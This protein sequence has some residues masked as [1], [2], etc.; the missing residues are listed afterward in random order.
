MGRRLK[1]LAA[2]CAMLLAASA[3]VTYVFA[4]ENEQQ[5]LND[6]REKD[7]ASVVLRKL[8]KTADGTVTEN[9]ISGAVFR[10]FTA[11]GTLVSGPYTTDENGEIRLSLPA[12]NYY[13]EEETPPDGYTF[14]WDRDGDPIMRYHFT[15]KELDESLLVLAYNRLDTYQPLEMELPNIIKKVEGEDIPKTEF[16]FALEG[17]YAYPMPEGAVGR[18]LTVSRVGKG[19][20]SLG[21]LTFT[22]PGTYTYTLYEVSDGDFSWT[23]DEAV[24]TLTFEVSAKKGKLI[25]ED[26]T[27]RKDEKTADE[28]IFTNVYEKIDLNEKI[29]VSGKKT[30]EHGTNPEAN[31]PERIIV[32]VYADGELVQQRE[33]TEKSNWEYSFEL[34]RYDRNGEEIR[35]VLDEEDVSGYSKAINGYDIVNTYTGTSGGSTS[36]STKPSA[37]PP[38]TGDE[39]ELGFWLAMAALGLCGFV[40][41]LILLLRTKSYRG[42]RLQKKGKRLMRK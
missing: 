36:D 37:K 14:D 20:V 32:K 42:R 3:L 6:L 16:T 40:T 2:L 22:L 19:T 39:F 11:E 30:W 12:G 1:R 29:T 27:I 23:Y 24:Y 10:L 9:V 5:A 8:E 13:F 31:R 25:C 38:K 33:V 4:W 41:V 34:Y 18:T 26:L 35:Y 17:K 7:G 21:T 28:I 15:V